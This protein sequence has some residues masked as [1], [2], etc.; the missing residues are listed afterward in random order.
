MFIWG[1]DKLNNIIDIPKKEPGRWA[2]I[3]MHLAI[4]GYTFT[5]LAEEHGL[6]VSVITIVKNKSYPNAQKI[7]ADKLVLKPEWIWPERYGAD[8]KPI[9]HSPRYPRQGITRNS[10][11]QRLTN[12]AV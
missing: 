2:T 5:K 12:K 11:R 9:S 10:K 7:I 8:G 3:K 4:R 6:S 1:M